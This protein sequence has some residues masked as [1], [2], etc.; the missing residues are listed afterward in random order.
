MSPKAKNIKDKRGSK[1]REEV[2][3][4][5]LDI[6]AS[7]SSKGAV[8]EELFQHLA[9]HCRSSSKV[10]WESSLKML[11]ERYTGSKLGSVGDGLYFI[12]LGQQEGL[13]DIACCWLA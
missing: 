13:S 2:S 1:R 4:A 9:K 5:G 10:A 8:L 3:I 11:R 12:E 6:A 7:D